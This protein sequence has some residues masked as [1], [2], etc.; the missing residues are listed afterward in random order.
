MGSTTLAVLGLVFGAWTAIALWMT[1]RAR[2][3]A[4]GASGILDESAR[5]AALVTAGPSLPLLVEPDGQARGS[6]QLAGLLGFDALP[7]NHGPTC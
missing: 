4:A 6:A 5:F 2:R 3:L 7:E 1:A